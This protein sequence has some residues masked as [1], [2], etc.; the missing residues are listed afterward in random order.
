MA[1]C[2]SAADD[3]AA[4]RCRLERNPT[5]CCP[6]TSRVSAFDWSGLGDRCQM[7]DR[8]HSAQNG[9]D[10]RHEPGAEPRPAESGYPVDRGVEGTPNGPPVD[11]HLALPAEHALQVGLRSLDH[12]LSFLGG[13]SERPK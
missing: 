13:I 12:V 1:G 11:R 7:A 8:K 10:A 2:G 6:K 3:P 4:A 5:L 9:E